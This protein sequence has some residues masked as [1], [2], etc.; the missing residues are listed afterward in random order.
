[1]GRKNNYDKHSQKGHHISRKRHF[2][3]RRRDAMR[4]RGHEARDE[5]DRIRQRVLSLSGLHGPV[6]TLVR[7]SNILVAL[8]CST[9]HLNVEGF[10][11]YS[12]ELS[13]RLFRLEQAI[14]QNTSQ[15][16]WGNDDRLLIISRALI[17]KKRAD[18]LPY[19]EFEL[20]RD[21]INLTSSDSW[22]HFALTSLG[23]SA[24]AK[25]VLSRERDEL[26]QIKQTQGLYDKE[27]Y[28][29][30]RAA[31]RAANAE[32]DQDNFRELSKRSPFLPTTKESSCWGRKTS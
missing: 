20:C 11:A 8:N 22:A 26:R 18:E 31:E 32:I 19:S 1:M 24:C 12:E 25:A 23:I 4:M 6:N 30:H 29:S 3:Q 17:I 13:D 21:G 16:V 2:E 9:S 27:N 14:V 7:R 5:N 28:D 15:Q 10:C